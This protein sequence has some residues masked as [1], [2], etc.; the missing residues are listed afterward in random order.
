MALG[1]ASRLADFA[2]ECKKKKLKAF[3]SYKSK[4]D[5]ERILKKYCGGNDIKK[6]PPFVLE[7]VKIDEH[8]KELE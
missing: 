5:L 7:P 4:A 2:K 8:N 1:P 6:I 3:S